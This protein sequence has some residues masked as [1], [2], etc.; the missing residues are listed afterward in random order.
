MNDL[1]KKLLERRVIA[2][3]GTVNIEMGFYVKEALMTLFS[4]G[5]PKVLITIDSAGG[6][7]DVGLEIYDTIRVYPG[8][9]VGCA[10]TRAGSAACTILQACTWRVATQNGK[11]LIH[12]TK[13]EITWDVLTDPT[14]R[15]EY[16]R[17]KGHFLNAKHILARRTNKDLDVIFKKCDDDN[18]MP[19]KEALDFGLLDQVI[20]TFEDI[21]VPE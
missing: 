7:A 6:S 12:H 5:S 19:S 14:K 21:K 18:W 17:S 3:N 20:E 10:L 11:I 9:S 16:I 4:Q 15:D 2:L 8:I 13:F 1:Q